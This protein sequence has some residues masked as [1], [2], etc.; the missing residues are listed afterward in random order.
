MR[1]PKRH[2]SRVQQRCDRLNG[3]I[4]DLARMCSELGVRLESTEDAYRGFIDTRDRKIEELLYQ[5]E[6]VR[7][8]TE[9][10]KRIIERAATIDFNRCENGYYQISVRFN[11][12]FMGGIS[13]YGEDMRYIAERVARQIEH[14]IASSKFVETAKMNERRQYMANVRRAYQGG[15]WI[16]GE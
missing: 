10:C 3:K 8:R 11:G 1:R 13:R 12:D 7:E 4:K 14:E 5:L 9:T 6:R 15:E 16:D 2:Q